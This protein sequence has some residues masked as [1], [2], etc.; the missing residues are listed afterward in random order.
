M[1]PRQAH[2]AFVTGVGESDAGRALFRDP[3]DLAIEATRRAIDDAGLTRDDIDGIVVFR[4]DEGSAGALEIQDAMGLKVEWF[5]QCD[6]GPSQL[7][8]VFE[9]CNAVGMGRARHVIA[10]HASNEGTMRAR[11][12]KGGSLPGA[13]QGMPD[14]I[15][16]F[17]Q[18][19]LPFGAM[20]VVHM[21]AMYA[22]CHMDRYGTTREQLGAVAM[23]ERSNAA[24]NPNAIYRDPLTLEEYLS[25]RMIAEPLCL[26]DCDVPID[27]GSAIVIS[28]D[29]AAR[30]TRRQPIRVEATSTSMRSRSSWDQFDDLTTMMMRDAGAAL[31]EHTDYKPSDVDI[32]MLYDGFTFLVLNWLEALGFCDKGE[33]GA[34]VEGGERISLTGDLPVN[35]N[36]GQLSAGR[37]HGWGYVPEACLQLWGDAGERQVPDQPATAA[38][39]CGGGIFAGAML[40][41]RS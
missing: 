2:D 36:G 7:S 21:M 3:L 18:W 29:D 8:A 11:L 10:V 1:P 35:T 12:G 13:A 37:K 33:S 5:A 20:S 34:F 17:Q 23:V 25:A 26:F 41:S 22:R 32:A 27:F 19:M 31:W 16:G 14:R 40:L 24:L 39:G 30:D 38:I 6:V 9:G 28:R 4:P 15:R